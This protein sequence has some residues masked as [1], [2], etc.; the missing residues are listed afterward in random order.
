MQPDF[1]ARVQNLKQALG[2]IPDG[3]FVRSIAGDADSWSTYTCRHSEFQLAEPDQWLKGLPTLARLLVPGLAKPVPPW[4]RRKRK[5]RPLSKFL[6][7]PSKI[8]RYNDRFTR[9]DP[10]PEQAWF[11]INGIGADETIASL[12]AGYLAQLFRRPLT[13]L[14]KPSCGLL[15]DLGECTLGGEWGGIA[16]A[17]RTAFPPLYAALKAPD[18]ERVV[19][20]CHSQG[21]VVAAVLLA[22]LEELHPPRMQQPRADCPE[23]RIA[24]KLAAGWGFPIITANQPERQSRFVSAA[25]LQKLELYCF[26]NCATTMEPLIKPQRNQPP[27]PWIESYGNEHDLFARLGVFAPTSGKGAQ[28]IGGDRYLRPEAWGHLL[29]AH[30]LYPMAEEQQAQFTGSP[31]ATRLRP[32][33]DNHQ[34]SPRLFEYFTGR[35]PPALYMAEP[36]SATTS[37]APR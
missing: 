8:L 14:F 26:G 6:L 15:P 4:L 27:A 31:A 34:S 28:R 33:L 29:N 13:I 19:L 23:R 12:N 7:R 2:A 32:M 36:G 35:S 20:L 17:A 30:Y 5:L 37:T 9:R 24:A 22:L 1:R 16:A 21:T 25:E 18:R 3:N 11:F 10:T